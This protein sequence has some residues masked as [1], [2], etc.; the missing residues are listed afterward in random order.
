[1]TT[2][3][4]TTKPTTRASRAKRRPE[5]ELPPL[6]VQAVLDY[7]GPR[8]VA[9]LTSTQATQ[10]HQLA[11]H[12]AGQLGIM[13]TGGYQL[14]VETAGPDTV[15]QKADRSPGVRSTFDEPHIADLAELA[16]GRPQS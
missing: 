4:A 3:K 12:M 15:A 11:G 6:L 16:S 2:K 5:L 1:M 13:L 14:R 9:K 7:L 10:V 8:V